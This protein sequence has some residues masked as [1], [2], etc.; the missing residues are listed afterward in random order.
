MGPAVTPLETG[1]VRPPLFFFPF[2]SFFCLFLLFFPP[3]LIIPHSPHSPRGS[4]CT[5]S[6]KRPRCFP[7]DFPS[8]NSVSLFSLVLP[9]PTPIYNPNTALVNELSITTMASTV[10]KVSASIY[11]NLFF[12]AVYSNCILILNYLQ[13]ITCK[14]RKKNA[15]INPSNRPARMTSGCPA[16]NLRHQLTNS[17]QSQLFQCLLNNNFFLLGRRCLGCH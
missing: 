3:H 2:V 10:G 14:V 11:D 7:F 13:T 6:F 16:L 17:L 4:T 5:F 8:A 9:P 1:P 12:I 15:I